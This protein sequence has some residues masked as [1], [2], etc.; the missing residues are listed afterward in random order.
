M[1]LPG[2]ASRE[3]IADCF[4]AAWRLGFKSIAVYRAG[5]K[6][7]EPISVAEDAGCASCL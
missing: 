5:S 6:V 3:S 7:F 1:N 2:S 4:L